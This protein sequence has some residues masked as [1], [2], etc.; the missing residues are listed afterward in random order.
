[1][2]WATSLPAVVACSLLRDGL[3]RIETGGPL[4]HCQK[5]DSTTAAG[6]C[7]LELNDAE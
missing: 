4:R 3:R 7:F 5:G 1:M 2:T 6:N